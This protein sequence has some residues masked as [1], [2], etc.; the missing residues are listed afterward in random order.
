MILCI[1][2]V[3]NHVAIVN[4][5]YT[6]GLSSKMMLLLELSSLTF[7]LSGERE[8]ERERERVYFV[9]MSGFKGNK[10]DV[11]GICQI[12]VS[13]FTCGRSI[14]KLFNIYA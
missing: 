14:H 10:Y 8:R 1:F 4:N 5:K 11:F 3:I 7:S 2:A 12:N 9:T 13:A 6:I